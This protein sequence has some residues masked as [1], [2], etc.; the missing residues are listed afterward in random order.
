MTERDRNENSEIIIPI[1]LYILML[2]SF[3]PMV[4]SG[5]SVK[6]IP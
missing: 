3:L 4:D 6:V 2:E 1:K 5:M